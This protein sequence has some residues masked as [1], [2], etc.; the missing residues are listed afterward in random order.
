[1]T[2]RIVYTPTP[3][4]DCK[5][6]AKELDFQSRLAGTKWQCDHCWQIWSLDMSTE[7]KYWR[8][9]GNPHCAVI[10]NGE[11]DL[12]SDP[13]WRGPSRPTPRLMDPYRQQPDFDAKRVALWLILAIIATAIIAATAIAAAGGFS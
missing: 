13:G 9:D 1:M 5:P 12:V 8:R 6:P 10:A 4:H 11:G 7:G 3:M 2:G